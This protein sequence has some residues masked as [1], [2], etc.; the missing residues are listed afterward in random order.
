[1]LPTS[2][3]AL[4]S[5][6]FPVPVTL[7][8]VFA[9]LVYTRGWCRLRSALP[10]RV[11]AW[12]LAVFMT[13]LF[14]IWIA[15]GSSIATLDAELL[16]IHM[17]QHCLLM[18]AG[19]P[20]ILLAAPVLPFRHGLPESMVHGVLLPL[21]RCS[22]VWSFG[23]AITHPVFCWLAGTVTVIGW[24]VPALFE[25]GLRSHWWHETQRASF[26]AAGLLFWIPVVEAWPSVA[27]WPRWSIPLY[28]FLATLPCDALSAFL[29]FCDRVVYQSYLSAPPLLNNSPLQD[30]ERAGA[31]MWVFV[32]FVYLIP[33]VAVAIQILSPGRDRCWDDRPRTRPA[34]S[35][36]IRIF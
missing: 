23:R 19:P 12:R 30:Q 5:G 20:L 22:P 21:L 33:A 34:S 27:K 4:H 31:L 10:N 15:V 14:S 29:T 25:L 7:A 8:L 28:L 18:A 35:K 11:P 6:S 2:H 3:A 1:M 32:T 13:G 16:S 9:A 17:L 26:F 24:H 36:I